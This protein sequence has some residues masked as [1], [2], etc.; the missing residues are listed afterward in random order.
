[1][2]YSGTEENE[3]EHNGIQW[4][5]TEWNTLGQKRMK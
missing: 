1:M 2:E 4:D 3:I 5:R